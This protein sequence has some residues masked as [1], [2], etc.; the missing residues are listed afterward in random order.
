M[1]D[2]QLDNIKW[3]LTILM[4]LYHI[5]YHGNGQDYS[6]FMYIKNFGE[7]DMPAF[8][9]I[10][11]FLFWRNVEKIEDLKTK[12]L[13]R[14]YTLLIPYLLW[15]FIN[16]I[17]NNT[18]N[19]GMK[20]ID[21]RIFNVNILTDII[22]C[23]STPHFW[24]IFLLMFWA[25]FSP[26]LYFCYKD[27][28]FLTIMLISQL[29]Y[30]I[31]M[32]EN[33]LH[34][35]FVYIVYTWGGYLGYKRYNIL[36]YITELNKK[37]KTILLMVSGSIFLLIK[38]AMHNYDFE[39][40]LRVWLYLVE[41]IALILFTANTPMLLFGKKTNYEYC[42]WIFAVH[43]WFDYYISIIVNE[44]VEGLLYQVV[45]FT[46]VL[47]LATVSGIIVKKVCPR[48]FKLLVGGR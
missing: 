20:N 17:L 38:T 22:L 2:K 10:S 36:S 3:I 30:I 16:T 25:V 39:I 32:G 21:S 33:I 47:L 35:R 7:C 14:V 34:S 24:Y 48:M 12:L 29:V 15:N 5:Q 41:A 11:G 4:L 45:T 28:R 31:V 40:N 26:I 44:Y 13:N 37:K 42:F 23:N 8:A 9:L 19:I 27:K 46:T 6:A 18:V 1:R 43:F